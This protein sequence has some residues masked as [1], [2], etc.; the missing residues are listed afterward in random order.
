MSEDER[1][2]R[3]QYK[4]NR[5]KWIIIQAVALALVTVF[6]LTSFLVYD[7]MNRTYYI[8][9][10]EKG[11]VDY[12]VNLKENSFFED[13]HVGPNQSYVSSLIENVDA[14]FNY[15]LQMDNASVGFEYSYWIDAKLVISNKD[16]VSISLPRDRKPIER[17]IELFPFSYAPINTDEPIGRAVFLCGDEIIGETE[18]YANHSVAKKEY[19]KSLWEGLSSIFK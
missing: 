10:T 4:R 3:Q 17:K 18:L 9:Y 2:R 6:A 11:N 15:K 14:N 8:E 19:K 7:R 13:D 16:T 12:R 1:L 5:K